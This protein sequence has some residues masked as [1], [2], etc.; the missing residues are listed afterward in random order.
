MPRDLPLFTRKD[1]LLCEALASLA[2]HSEDRKRA[3][4]LVMPARNLGARIA[5]ALP[6]E[7]EP[8]D[9]ALEAM[10]MGPEDVVA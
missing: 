7:P 9:I 5:L 1:V 2:E 8:V 10:D 4:H 3:A 6:D